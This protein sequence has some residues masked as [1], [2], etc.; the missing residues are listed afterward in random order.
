MRTFAHAHAAAGT[1]QEV[2][3]ALLARLPAAPRASL[4]FLY[5][6]DALASELPAL[7]DHLKIHTGVGHWVGSVGLGISATATE[8]YDQP[9]AAVL[10]ADFPEDSFRVFGPVDA[11]SRGDVQRAL[12]IDG[13]PG[14]FAVIHADPGTAGIAELVADCA[15][16]VDSGFV[17]GGLSSSRDAAI[18]IADGLVQGGVSGVSLRADVPVLTRLTQGCTPI[19]PKH[20]ITECRRNILIRLDGRPALDVV[21]EDIGEVLSR[22]LDRAAGYIFAGLPVAGSDRGDY[23]VRNIMGYDAN[24]GL[25]AVGEM[26]EPGGQVMFC[27]RDADTAREDLDRVLNELKAE[28]RGAPRG[29]LY[30]SCL[31]RGAQLFGPDSAELRQVSDVLGDFP[32]VGFFANGEISHDRLYG[33]TGVLTLFP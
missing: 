10:L 29:G 3:R 22:N 26:L 16:S 2:A 24:N 4:G 30:F 28:L 25:I 1:W 14:H 13:T 11:R 7:L 9:A 17:V 15:R 33:Y 18:Q 6:T 32:L 5:V 21:R 19:G 31:G 20:D 8:Y 23:L 27:R 12:S